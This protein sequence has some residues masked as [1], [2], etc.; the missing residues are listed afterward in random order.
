MNRTMRAVLRYTQNDLKWLLIAATVIG[1]F[2]EGLGALAC[3]FD[4][5]EDA[6][7]IVMTVMLAIFF[8]I[9]M[10]LS[11]A[12][13]SNQ[14]PM[15]LSFS[16]TRRGLTAGILLHSLRL[17]LMLVALAFVWG[18]L[19]ALVRRVL[20][21][22]YPL[23]WQWMP[24]PVWPA[25]LVL[26]L[27]IGLLLGGLLQRFGAAGFWCAYV[28]ILL[29]ASSCGQ[30]LDAALRLLSLPWPVLAAGVLVIMGGVASLSLHWMQRAVVK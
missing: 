20:T 21:G 26:P 29:G 24:W 12:Y 15:F 16:A 8:L 2:G 22:A 4:E 6:G 5:P 7:K 27:W 14:F 11:I 10:I 23:P 19:D 13:L 28:V 18:T 30:W 25:V 17:N 9:S 1:L 3:L